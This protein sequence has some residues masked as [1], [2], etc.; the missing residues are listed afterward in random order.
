MAQQLQAGT[1]S[2]TLSGARAL[3]WTLA[4]GFTGA[5]SFALGFMYWSSAGN[6]AVDWFRFRMHG[7]RKITGIDLGFFERGPFDDI[8]VLAYLGGIFGGMA[9]MAYGLI[10]AIV[11]REL[12]RGLV[13]LMCLA[14]AGAGSVGIATALAGSI[15][16]NVGGTIGGFLGGMVSCGLIGFVI[17]AVALTGRVCRKPS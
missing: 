13:V 12:G 3:A 2:R 5:A 15:A 7:L 14:L 16:M 17:M 4:G 11:R 9:G 8:F 6:T 1:Q 10:R